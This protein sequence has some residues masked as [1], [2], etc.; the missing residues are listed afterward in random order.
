[1]SFQRVRCCIDQHAHSSQH[2][3][4]GPHPF[5]RPVAMGTAQHGTS[6]LLGSGSTC[7][8]AGFHLIGEGLLQAG[9]TCLSSGRGHLLPVLCR[10]LLSP[11][12]EGTRPMMEKVR[13][14]VFNMLQSLSG[15]GNQLPPGSRWLDLYAGTGGC[16]S[17]LSP[18]GPC[19]CCVLDSGGRH[20]VPGGRT[21]QS[22]WPDILPGQVPSGD[23]CALGCGWSAL[24]CRAVLV[25]DAPACK[26][27]LVPCVAACWQWKGL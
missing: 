21:R 26:Q 8:L 4:N 1:M 24:V 14:A 5:V 7:V 13:S 19:T 2:D 9:T 27:I 10:R 12:G 15:L 20:A 3:M 18:L 17:K 22:Q 16:Q 23:G 6:L 25:A 11:P